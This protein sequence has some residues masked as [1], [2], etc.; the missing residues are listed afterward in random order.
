MTLI[1]YGTFLKA[2][3]ALM[4]TVRV[5]GQEPRV[6]DYDELS[7]G[8]NDTPLIQVYPVRGQGNSGAGDRLTFTG[9]MR[10]TGMTVIIRAYARRRAMLAEDMNAQIKLIDAIDE[11]LASQAGSLFGMESVM[12][13]H[14]TWERATYAVADAEYAGAEFTLDIY[15][16]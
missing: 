10:R 3:G 13:A 12:A 7:E 1:T 2:V 11:V 5:D 9:G 14:W 8:I 16:T 6:Q 4:R 15:V